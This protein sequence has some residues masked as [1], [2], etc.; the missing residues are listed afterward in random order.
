MFKECLGLIDEKLLIVASLISPGKIILLEKKYQQMKSIQH[1]VSSP[2]EAP[3]SSSKILRCGLYFQL[4]S[5]CFICMV[6]KHCVSWF[7]YYIKVRSVWDR[8]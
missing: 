8:L 5:Q 6:M 7:I 1:S 3:R 2:D 4:S